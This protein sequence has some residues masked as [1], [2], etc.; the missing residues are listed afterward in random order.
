MRHVR[1]FPK[2]TRCCTSRKQNLFCLIRL[3]FFTLAIVVLFIFLFVY[4]HFVLFISLLFLSTFPFLLNAVLL[5]SHFPT[6][7]LFYLLL[8]PLFPNDAA[9]WA[10]ILLPILRFSLLIMTPPLFLTHLATSSEAR[11]NPEQ[12]ATLKRY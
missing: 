5:S 12:V 2:N 9:C 6:F 4:L 10:E 11:D 1:I 3:C 7:L 8:L